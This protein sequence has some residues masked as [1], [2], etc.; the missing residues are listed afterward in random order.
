MCFWSSWHSMQA[1]LPMYLALG[2]T[3]PD[4]LISIG[5]APISSVPT[6]LRDLSPP[7]RYLAVAGST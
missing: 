5:A 1:V 6:D 4:I 7:G 3:L 2:G